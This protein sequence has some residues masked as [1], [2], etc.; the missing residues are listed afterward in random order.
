MALSRVHQG[1]GGHRAGHTKSEVAN[2]RHRRYSTPSTVGDNAACT[3]QRETCLSRRRTGARYRR[4][5]VVV[6]FCH[7]RR[8]LRWRVPSRSWHHRRERSLMLEL[9][10]PCASFFSNPAAS[11]KG[12]DSRPEAFFSK[13]S[14]PPL[15]PS[16][17][18]SS[19]LHQQ[20]PTVITS[21]IWCF[22]VQAMHAAQ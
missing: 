7:S 12:P 8:Y 22:V 6:A 15:L 10:M 16:R 13:A 17:A 18:D 14:R 19:R 2:T 1:E 5:T 11:H 20:A 4:I 3:G 9:R 21:T